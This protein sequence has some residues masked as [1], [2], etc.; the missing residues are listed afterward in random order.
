MAR[1][2]GY[3]W[4]ISGVVIGAVLGGGGYWRYSG[5]APEE[6]RWTNSDPLTPT[7]HTLFKALV[8]NTP[9]G[10]TW[11]KPTVTVYS[12][13]Y[14]AP[15]PAPITLRDFS[16]TAQ[17]HVLDLI[18]GPAAPKTAWQDLMKKIGDPASE[19]ERT[20][21][22]RANRVLI[23][24]VLKGMDTLPG[25]RLLWTRI[26]VQPINFE[27]AG[28]TIAATD[29]RTLKLASIQ[30]ATST[31]LSV[32]TGVTAP[33]LAKPDVGQ[34]IERTQTATTDLSEQYENL[35]IDIE[36][37]FLRIVRESSA[38]GDVS[39]NTAV[40]LSMLTD[41]TKIWCKMLNGAGSCTPKAEYADRLGLL[42]T[43][44][45][46]DGPGEPKL[47]VLPQTLLPHCPLKAKVWMLYEMRQI[48]SG[49][50]HVMEGRQQIEISKDAYDAEEVEIVPADD[51]APAVWSIKL[52]DGEEMA[53]QKSHDLA[54]RVGDSN[55]RPLVF[56]D[57]LTA[58]E[59]SH[60]LKDQLANTPAKPPGVGNMTFPGLT[61][62]K[63][64]LTPY[65]YR[66]NDC[67]SKI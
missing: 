3:V 20:D 9:H 59:L 8:G 11:R 31:K 36:P 18:A 1:I 62:A 33:G 40:E 23:A 25:D 21:P 51:I 64:R 65:K 27:F 44:A 34:D 10:E 29:S 45:R 56:T 30:N 4:A 7:E 37:S 41:A 13:P 63:K 24:T 46:F 35:G 17:A 54:A 12:A 57:F 49:R 42:V 61:D 15:R 55:E 50:Q 19:A 66:E 26:F 43:G 53:S 22:Y 52:T 39:G 6:Q 67:D 47:N 58:S 32:S 48:T 2:P 60:W 14:L 28:Y 38:G 5:P 16:N